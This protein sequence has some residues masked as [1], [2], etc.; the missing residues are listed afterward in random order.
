MRARTLLIVLMTMTAAAACGGD[1]PAEPESTLPIVIPEDRG[2]LARFGAPPSRDRYEVVDLK[3]L[4]EIVD[5]F[6]G[7][8]LLLNFWATWCVP[9]VTEIPELLDVGR[10]FAREGRVLGV[11][12]D[13]MLPGE[14]RATAPRSVRTFLESREWD[15]DVVVYDD[16]GY[17]AINERYGLPGEIPVT[18]AL[19]RNGRIVDRQEGQA[20]RER[21]AEMMRTALGRR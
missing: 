16:R 11:S 13:L 7:R 9:C 2:D 18:L 1:A 19:D 12:Y 4:D 8:A 17:R 15:F 5:G 14:S 3:R 10:E 20:T 21:F 6:R